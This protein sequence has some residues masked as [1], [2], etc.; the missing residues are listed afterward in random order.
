MT[1]SENT[2]PARACFVCRKH[3]GEIVALHGDAQ[4]IAVFCVWLRA[5]LQT[6]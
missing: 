2:A 4:A 6:L 5:S 1:A 3:R